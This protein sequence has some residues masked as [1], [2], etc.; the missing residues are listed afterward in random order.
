MITV[1]MWTLMNTWAQN[2]KEGKVDQTSF[3]VDGM[4]YDELPELMDR[5][6]DAVI[7][8]TINQRSMVNNK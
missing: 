5:V 2:V 7:R 3:V 8:Y 4:A 6:A 1:R